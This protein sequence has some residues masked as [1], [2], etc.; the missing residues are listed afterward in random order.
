M[1]MTDMD[2]PC[3]G[4][5]RGLEPNPWDED[6]MDD[7][8]RASHW[9]PF[10]SMTA[11]RLADR[12]FE[13]A[14]G[15]EPGDDDT[16]WEPYVRCHDAARFAMFDLWDENHM[17]VHY[18]DQKVVPPDKALDIFVEVDGFCYSK[19]TR[20]YVCVGDGIG[21]ST[22]RKMLKDAQTAARKAVAWLF[23]EEVTQETERQFKALD[24]T[25]ESWAVAKPI[26]VLMAEREA[27]RNKEGAAD[28]GGCVWPEKGE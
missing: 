2:E 28:S 8:E 11:T 4:D 9:R 14:F 13:V 12:I 27:A 7:N 24:S 16:N 21:T 25:K 15:R 17:A 1:N 20:Y 22:Y 18:G 10:S 6:I 3:Y 5:E 19:M 23:G 26:Q